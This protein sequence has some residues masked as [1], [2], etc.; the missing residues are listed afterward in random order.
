ML[1]RATGTAKWERAQGG[2]IRVPGT[3]ELAKI[4]GVV[5]YTMS[6]KNIY[7]NITRV[8]SKALFDQLLSYMWGAKLMLLTL[9][10][11]Y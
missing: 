10:Y 4:M 1:C 8:H 6:D 3:M 5:Y 9:Y 11:T 7:P 2:I